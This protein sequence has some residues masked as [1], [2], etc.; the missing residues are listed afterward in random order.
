MA[1]KISS[2][3]P[4]DYKISEIKRL[5]IESHNECAEPNCDNS[6][7]GEDNITVIGKICHIEA[8]NKNGPRFNK[9]MDNDERRSYNNLILLCDEHHRIIDNPINEYKYT[10]E[11]LLKWKRDHIS[12]NRNSSYKISID[13]IQQ[14]IN[15]TK[16]YYQKIDS[17]DGPYKP[18]VSDD[19]VTRDIQ[20]ELSEMLKKEK[21]LLL[22]G[23][24]FCGKSQ[25][26]F[27]IANDFYE[28]G[29]LYKRVLNTRD[30]SLFLESIG[31]KRI[32]ILED[33]FGH[34][35]SSE[36][37]S[38]LK[39]VRDMLK[40]L[41]KDNL[42]I[43]TSKKEIVLS[44]NNE[45][46]LKDCSIG[47]H[48]WFDLTSKDRS[49][50]TIAWKKL[51]EDTKILVENVS[52]VE[53]LI[54]NEYEIQVGQ[55]AYLSKM[56][57]LRSEIINPKK[58]YQLAQIDIND[59]CNDILDRNDLSWKILAL[60]GLGANTKDGLT[61]N[62]FDY[63][64]EREHNELSL[65]IRST[66]SIL[67][68][69]K[70]AKEFA[71]PSYEISYNNI[72]PIEVVLE[73]L[74]QIGFIEFEKNQFIFRHPHYQEI[75][76]N[77]LKKLS[78]FKRKDL[79]VSILNLLTCLNQESAF[80]C[81]NNLKLIFECFE[82]FQELIIEKTYYTSERSFFPKVSDSCN[83]FLMNIYDNSKMEF[84]RSKI[85]SRLQRKSEEYGILFY[86]QRPYRYSHIDL[87]KRDVI[88]SSS[89]YEKN[90]ISIKNNESLSVEN[91]W[92]SLITINAL[93][94]E[95]NIEILEYAFKSNEVFIRNICVYLYFLHLNIL[96]D[97]HLKDKI[98]I[99]EH[100]SIIYFA[101][102]GFFQGL[103]LNNLHLNKEISERFEYFFKSDKVFCIRASTLMTNFD[104]DYADDSI[105]W[106]KIP[107]SKHIWVWRIW[108]KFFIS[109][110]KVFPKDIR[111]SHNARYSGM[112]DKA[113]DV[114][115]PSQGKMITK[116]MLKRLKEISKARLLDH[117]EMN[118]IEFFIVS[119]S[120]EPELRKKIFKKFFDYKLPTYFVGYNLV[121]T[122]GIWD[123][124]SEKEKIIIV[125]TV[126]EDRSDKIWLQAIVLNDQ[127][128]PP[129]LLIKA[130]FN[131][132]EFLSQEISMLID[133]ID[134]NLL[135]KMIIVYI[136]NDN[137]F[138][139]L[140]ISGS[141]KLV[142]EIIYYIVANH[143]P[144]KYEN[145]LFIFL[146]HF[147]NS[148]PVDEFDMYKAIWRKTY[149]QAEN[150]F[151]L[152]DT[153][154]KIV[155][156]STFCF[157]ETTYLFKVIIDFH[158]ERNEGEE[159]AKKLADNFEYLNYSSSLRDLIKV[160]NT[161]DFFDEYL[162]PEMQSQFRVLTLLYNCEENKYSNED[163]KLITKEILDITSR[164][165]VKL[166]SIFYTIS[167][168]GN[169]ENFNKEYLDKL[170]EIPNTIKDRQKEYFQIGKENKLLDKFKYYYNVLPVVV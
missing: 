33:P 106:D 157:K 20:S 37:K 115:Y 3:G 70:K 87:Y 52:G 103:H 120:K 102:K 30:A 35:F 53:N 26:A 74:E 92:N 4:R 111:Y 16:N 147:I 73:Y 29:Y 15:E 124:L 139:E 88:L 8:A 10:K 58:L 118:L 57:E 39:L 66:D 161:Q 78:R 62:D 44:V 140:S 109:F 82:E 159:L 116:N 123:I 24:S 25:T 145:C 148:V 127:L 31:N 131:D 71:L 100:P 77:I 154:I 54:I 34:T 68:S 134:R 81:A 113:K 91:V 75:S 21:V 136:G 169:N 38:E 93:K 155:G 11:E 61:L 36:K 142:K 165:E 98:L 121:W 170:Q 86:D 104:T 156:K 125:N 85:A 59:I 149:T 141:S 43:I 94:L 22:T 51:T 79:I 83:L 117:H 6:L 2:V 95:P 46:R 153:V 49:F 32:C 28:S 107:E 18:K 137:A 40:T 133:N 150:Q 47:N 128:L 5:F 135:E 67:N 84:Y 13:H 146:R 7:I 152:L 110:L 19:Y 41:P 69:S 132:S 168:L 96:Y 27:S 166:K 23:I 160:L 163:Q 99:D 17:L 122:F 119:T 108:A 101:L 144:V 55:L 42:L 64:L 12:R 65:E 112:M 130:I 167:D 151:E 90:I 1:K 129:S 56:Q 72:Y 114:V 80:I 158:L 143:I 164:E 63:I 105:L 48:K 126:G 89:E 76:K 162:I 14:F 45:S 97:S 9:K 60:L 138:H 50:L